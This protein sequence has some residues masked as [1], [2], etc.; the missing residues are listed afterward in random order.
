MDEITL[1]KLWHDER[2]ALIRVA[3]GLGTYADAV[4]LAHC[5][6]H[7]DLF[8]TPPLPNPLENEPE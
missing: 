5:M 4:F 3:R 8:E 7:R 2:D 6:N 1:A